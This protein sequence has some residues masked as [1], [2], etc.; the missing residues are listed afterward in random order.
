[1][2]APEVVGSDLT[3]EE[4]RAL[5]DG[6]RRSLASV[7]PMVIEAYQRRAWLALGYASWEI[8]C[9]QELAGMRPAIERDQRREAVGQMREAGMSQRAIA[10]AVG[11][12]HTTVGD[13]LK[14]G[15]KPPPDKIQGADGK[16]YPPIA[17]PAPVDSWADWT[18]DE[19]QMRKAVKAGEIVIASMRGD[20]ERVIGWA[21]SE[22]LA[23]RI[24]RRS[25]WGNPFEM[26]GDG[27]RL[28]VIKNYDRYYLPHK[29]SLL[30]RITDLRGRLLICWCAPES[31]HGDVLKRR[32]EQ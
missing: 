7:W 1:M 31:C 10:G 4:A 32:A 8:Y 2:S 26:P 23:V 13:D 21:E 30:F 25:Q 19:R 12:N 24:D 17:R 20:H 29:P 5:T 18:I 16:T 14:A 28:T 22:G 11:V 27:D 9:D 6:I 15:G 3:A